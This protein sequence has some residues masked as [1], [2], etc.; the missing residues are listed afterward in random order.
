MKG[1]KFEGIYRVD[2]KGGGVGIL[3]KEK[4]I[5]KHIQN[6]Q[7]L[8]IELKGNKYNVIIASLYQPPNTDI[9]KFLEEYNSTL[10]KI[11]KDTKKEIILGMDHNL[12]LLKQTR[13]K[14]TQIFVEN[15]LDHSLLPVI[16]KPTGISK[17]SAT[18]IDNIIISDKMLTSYK[19]N[20]VFS[21]LSNHL[22]CY[23]EINE[24]YA[25]KKEVTKIKKRKLNKENLNKIKKDIGSIDWQT[26]LSGIGASKSFDIFH[27][28]LMETIDKM[29]PECEISLRNKREKKTLD[30]QRHS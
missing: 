28:R 1:Y 27:K 10:E 11:G 3:I 29:A 21:N 25:G 15:T 24:F 7:N 23:V 8:F 16:M 30:Q 13:H 2:K 17:T 20:I 6:I 18:L 19:S 12:D 5:Y 26:T 22:P 9:D 4:L 14:K